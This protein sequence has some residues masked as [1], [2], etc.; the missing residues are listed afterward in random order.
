ML[1][2]LFLLSGSHSTSQPSVIQQTH[3]IVETCQAHFSGG[4]Q[5][6]GGSHQT[7]S[8]GKYEFVIYYFLAWLT[9]IESKLLCYLLS[10]QRSAHSID[11]L[12]FGNSQWQGS[13]FWVAFQIL[14]HKE[15]NFVI[16]CPVSIIFMFE[17]FSPMN[18]L[19]IF[20]FT[21]SARA[22][23]SHRKLSKANSWGDDRE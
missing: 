6:S 12:S 4:S 2:I 15:F 14:T 7:L 11:L 9:S 20:I 19:C 10:V 21:I 23:H 1:I 18:N 8:S 3:V 5:I 13:F 16:E 17:Y 22:I